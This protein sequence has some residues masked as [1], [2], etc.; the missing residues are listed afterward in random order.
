MVSQTIE[1]IFLIAFLQKKIYFLLKTQFFYKKF[2][3][4]YKK[5]ILFCLC[6]SCSSMSGSPDSEFVV[7]RARGV[8]TLTDMMRYKSHD[9]DDAQS[10][11]A[12]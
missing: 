6:V 11:W 3:L 8:N 2:N 7:Q 12:Y 5:I 9:M 10:W 4:F 1:L